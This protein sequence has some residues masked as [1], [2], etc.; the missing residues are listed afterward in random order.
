M[1]IKGL[2]AFRTTLAEGSLVAA[3]KKL[4]LSQPALSRLIAAL[5]ADLRLT[6]FDRSGRNLRPTEQGLAF[7]REAGR[8]LD[9]LDEIPSIASEI[10]SGRSMSLRIVT[11]PRV[12]Q[13]LV[14]PVMAEFARQMPDINSSLD[15][16]ARREAS[17]WLA[18]REYDLGIGA[19]PVDHPGIDTEL[20]LRVRAQAI[21]PARH[22]LVDRSHLTAEDIAPYPVIRLMQGLLLRDQLDDFFQSAGVTVKQSCEVASS[23][24]ACSLVAE[25]GGITIADEL[26]ASQFPTEKIVSIPIIPERWMSFGLL[27]PRN[28]EVLKAR[29]VFENLMR[30]RARYLASRS[31]AIMTSAH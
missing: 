6:L 27:L 31:D 5:E 12:A 24:L 22:P 19:L 2:R 9:N 14:A 20:L 3:S 15:V 25:G 16:R 7:Y 30:K 26:L 10:R 1:N 13:S 8:I 11:M 17:K 28:S 21:V 4:H 18:G 29:E 23:I